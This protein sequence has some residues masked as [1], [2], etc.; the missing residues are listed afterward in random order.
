MSTSLRFKSVEEASSRKARPV[1]I[2]AERP[3]VYYASK[4]FNRQKMFEY[5]S[6]EAFDALAQAIDLKRPLPRAVAD[7]V[8]EGMRRWAI[9]NGARH[10]T[11]WFQPMTDGTAEKHDAFIDQEARGE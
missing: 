11:H 9:D 8:A 1:E 2:P 3:E 4:V 10:Y 6:K 5:L 7:A